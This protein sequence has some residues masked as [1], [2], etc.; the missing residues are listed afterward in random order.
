LVFRGIRDGFRLLESDALASRELMS[1]RDSLIDLLSPLDVANRIHEIGLIAFES[2]NFEDVVYP[3]IDK[4][5][6]TMGADFVGIALVD[7][8][9]SALFHAW[10]SVRGQGPIFR[11]HR[12]GVGD[13][14]VG[15]MFA[16]GQPVRVDD[17]TEFPGYVDLVPGM[18]SELTVPL[19]V[20]G[21]IIGGIDVESSEVGRFGE[22]D[23]RL[24]V[25]LASPVAQA[26]H[27]AR[28]HQQ[29]RHRLAQLTMLNRVA[30]IVASTIDV[31][32]MLNS[33]V[34]AIREALG[35]SFVGVGFVDEERGLVTLDAVSTEIPIDLQIGHS[36]SLGTGVVG[37]VV[38]S[39][40]SLLV[41][42]VRQRENFVSAS[43]ELTCEMCCPLLVEGR[44][45]GSLDAEEREPGAFDENDLMLLET[46]ADHIAQALANARTLERLERLRQDLTGMLVHDLRN[47]LTVIQ[48]TLDYVKL[49][50]RRAAAADAAADTR[51]SATRT[52]LE[53]ADAACTEMA[54]MVDSILGLNKIEAGAQSL[55]PRPVA[56]GE[57][58]EDIAARWAI[59]ADAAGVSLECRVADQLPRVELDEE[60]VTRVIKNLVA[61][62]IKFTPAGGRIALGIEVAAAELVD[63]RLPGCEGAVVFGV[64]DSGHGIPEEELERIFEKFATV[65]SRRAG[66]KYSTGPGLAFCKL[67]VEA[68]GGAIWAERRIGEGSAFK[69]LIPIRTP[70]RWS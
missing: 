22:A 63:E 70:D 21:E 17:V 8:G 57:L 67:A 3:I 25:A 2:T 26:I 39:G 49:Q 6:E 20:G 53:Q 41:P 32:D 50:Q 64:R 66:K 40:Q 55:R 58:I 37:E 28:L 52:Y 44:V 42:D 35:C 47:P 15:R 62:A 56:V 11:E 5:M 9:R 23:I 65:E 14:V 10:G 16:T 60:L 19:V 4:I 68:H 12:Q 33:T 46:V 31:R 34:E 43:P 18:R 13:G 54:L 30:R 48:S 51:A 29:E 24:L 27:S 61:N 38:R 69:V 45:V 7:Q 1:Q 59:V 36:Q